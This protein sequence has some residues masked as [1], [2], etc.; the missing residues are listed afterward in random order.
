MAKMKTPKRSHTKLVCDGSGD[1]IHFCAKECRKK[2]KGKKG[3]VNWN[4]QK[5]LWKRYRREGKGRFRNRQKKKKLS[6]RDV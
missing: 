4:R 1:G 3:P 5:K 2:T 6:M